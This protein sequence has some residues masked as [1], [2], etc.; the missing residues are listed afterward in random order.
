VT[1]AARSRQWFE[2][3]SALPAVK[4]DYTT[5]LILVVGRRVGCA[6]CSTSREIMAQEESEA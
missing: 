1:E 6:Y 4:Y 5:L 2:L 3:C